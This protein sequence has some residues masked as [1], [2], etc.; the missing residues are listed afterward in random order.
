MLFE[1]VTGGAGSGKSA[2]IEN[3]IEDLINKGKKALVIVPERFSHIEER[4]LC[5][6][7]GG[8]GL[9]NIEVTTFS[10]LARR[11]APKGEYLLKSGREM[12]VLKAAK[13][14]SS[15]GDGIFEG[16]YEHGG[17]VEQISSTITELKRNLITPDMME[18]LELD[19]FLGRKMSAVSAIYRAYN[20]MFDDNLKDPDET[21]AELAE[22]IEADGG[23]LNTVVFI[24][25]FSDFMPT[26]YKVIEALI[27]KANSVIVALTINDEGLRDS[28]GIYAPVAYSVERLSAI[29]KEA[30]AEYKHT[31]LNGE[32]DYVKSEDLRF[33]L[34]NYDSYTLIREI[35]ECNNIK[36][37]VCANRRDEVERLAG[38]IMYEVRENNLRFRDIGV[39]IGNTDSYLHIIE[40]VFSEYGIPYFSDNKM[41]A[42]EHPVI[43]MVLSVFGVV[44]ENWSFNSVFKYLRSGFIYK[45]T[46]SGIEKVDLRGIDR[47]EIYCRSRGIRGKNIWLSEDAWKPARKG[48][49]DAATETREDDENIEDLDLLRRELMA[50]FKTL[51]EKIRGK[52]KVKDLAKGLFEFLNDICLYDGLVLEQEKLEENNLLDD[53]LS[54]GEVWDAV[55]ETLDQAVLTSGEEYMSREDFSRMIESGFSKCT[56][57]TVPSG[58]D[59]VSVG[60]ADTSRPVRVKALFVLGAVRG[61]LPP[62]VADGGII[63]ESD[64]VMLSANGYDILQGKR[65]RTQIAEFN[66]FSSLTAACERLYISYPEMNDEGAKA[67]PAAIL[68]ELERCFGNINTKYKQKTEWENILASG[69]STYNKL[70]SR[71]SADIPEKE[72]EF[73]NE[74]WEY[75]SAEDK[76]AEFTS[77]NKADDNADLSIF[78]VVEGK[79]EDIL[80]ALSSYNSGTTHIKPTTAARLYG[81]NKKFSITALQK[82]NECPFA[83]FVRYG[84]LLG[85]D[86][87]YK[88]GGSD[89]GKMVHWAVCEFCRKVQENAS[90]TEEKK[91]CWEQLDE[92][93][94]KQV[95]VG[96]IADVEKKSIESNPE[97]CAERLALICKK[98]A[99]T[100]NRSAKVIKDSLISGGFSAIDFEKKFNCT[101]ERN[102][103]TVDIEGVID[104]LDTAEDEKGKLLRVID[105]KTGIQ[106]FSVADIYNRTDLQLII[107]AIAAEKMYKDDNA[108][109][110]A[111]MYNKVRDELV[112]T[113][114]G[115]PAAIMSAPLDG[116]IV[117]DE[118]NTA[119]EEI[120]I[121]DMNLAEKETKSSF[122]PLQ[123]KKSGGLK[124]SNTIISRAKFNMLTKYVTKT[125]VGTKRQV[126]DGY[127]AP[128][129]AE[130]REHSACDWCE[131]SAICLHSNDRDGVRE[132]LTANAKAWEKIEMEDTN[133]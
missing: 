120:L 8:L 10:K 90:T 15:A 126:L 103:E 54:I 125:A 76:K 58:I 55:L 88:V 11:L 26:H 95:I 25:G 4:T 13:E 62:E 86:S 35:P 68:G 102:G 44:I 73:W 71:I 20:A 33:F 131:Y 27:K 29:A 97:F 82:Y 104:R 69:R 51:L 49:F 80:S 12:L 63:T 127:I 83:Y 84:L 43:R 106:K 34:S 36:L 2:C 14:N 74:I 130:D 39:I 101:L 6:R 92:E 28:D 122:L 72:R 45:K 41:S 66:I 50:P 37:S 116:V 52:R 22:V 81:E 87:E 78:Q 1:L 123:T 5:A 85:D 119:D 99:N 32:F 24:D 31:H 38:R 53:A 108:R 133:E 124:K 91:A 21:M 75:V 23:F 113:K 117:T 61:E 3:R 48:L 93:K 107:Y 42:L 19:G 59:R 77:V 112:K 129:P 121:H 94:A 17:F 96:I 128:Y 47:L 46:E 105:Y 30:C 57:D 60:R 70:I 67:T 100:L 115:A 114:F 79:R 56:I 110:S 132:K 118:E 89:I 40:T 16:A 64:R 65:T 18:N 9:N 109:V 7:F 98:V 111:V